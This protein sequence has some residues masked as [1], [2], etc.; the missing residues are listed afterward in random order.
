MRKK[1]W[2]HAIIMLITGFL[3]AGGTLADDRTLVTSSE[4]YKLLEEGNQRFLQ[5]RFDNF[6]K[7]EPRRQEVAKGE[8][9]FAIIV[10]CSDS[11]V[12]PEV[13]FDQGLGDLAA[14]Q[15]GASAVGHDPLMGGHGK[16][17]FQPEFRAISVRDGQSYPWR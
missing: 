16:V 9:P 11:R 2:R 7:M 4:A 3:L 6:K 17:G 12:P 8:K 5:G 15:G 1:T 14:D 10:S 13:V